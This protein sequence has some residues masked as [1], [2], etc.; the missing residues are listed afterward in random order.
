MRLSGAIARTVG[1]TVVLWLTVAATQPATAAVV[2]VHAER[3]VDTIEI[4]ANAVLSAD[5]PTAWRVLTEYDR[6]AEFIPDLRISHV[7][8]RRAESVTVEQSGF[9]ALWLLRIPVQVTFEINESP[10]TRMQSRAISGTLR[11][12]TSCYAL[13]PTPSGV[14]MDYAGRVTPGFA[15]AGRI[16][17]AAVKQNI[18]RQFQALADEIERQGNGVMS[19]SSVRVP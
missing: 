18:A 15:L 5:A 6:Y 13:T 19:L 9:A 1:V 11:A 3:G 7:V 2:T 10:P 17:M 14:R 12:L 16:E 4:Q 8:A